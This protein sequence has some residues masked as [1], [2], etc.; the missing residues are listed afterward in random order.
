A[1]SHA[2]S[3]G[4]R[5]APSS[6]SA[7]SLTPTALMQ[8]ASVQPFVDRA[9]AT[10]ASFQL[11]KENAPAVAE[12]CDRLEGL[13]LALELAAARAGI[14][15]PQQMLDQ[16]KERFAFL[17]SRQRD[18]PPRHRTLRAALDSSYQ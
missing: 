13:P 3:G 6:P 7:Q 10:H 14:L 5:S 15:A 1:R 8:Y 16:L 17:V 2:V 18:V 4:A 12:L 11:T 9:Q